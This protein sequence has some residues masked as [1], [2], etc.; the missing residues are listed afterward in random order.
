MKNYAGTWSASVR[1]SSAIKPQC[2]SLNYAGRSGPAKQNR[3]QNKLHLIDKFSLSFLRASK[4]NGLIRGD[5]RKQCPKCCSEN[6]TCHVATRRMQRMDVG[7][8]KF[9][10]FVPRPVSR[11][12]NCPQDHQ[13]SE[14]VSEPAQNAAPW[15]L[16]A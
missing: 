14:T 3:L 8:Q 11:K 2:L 13:F 16:Q 15:I 6:L 12:N 5:F 10:L 9:S 1:Y 7:D 4:K